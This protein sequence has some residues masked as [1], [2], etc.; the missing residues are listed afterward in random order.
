MKTKLSLTILI[1]IA[2][3]TYFGSNLSYAV[4]IDNGMVYKNDEINF[5][6]HD[7]FKK[8]LFKGIFM[9]SIDLVDPA[10]FDDLEKIEYDEWIT[11]S[12]YEEQETDDIPKL[13][14][15]GIE[16]PDFKI[17]VETDLA[18]EALDGR[19]DIPVVMN[20]TVQYFIDYFT[21]KIRKKFSVWLSR[22]SKYVPMMK[23]I[24]NIFELPEDLVYLALIE[25][26][27]YHHARS[28]ANAVGPWQFIYSTAKRYGLKIDRWVDERRDPEKSTYAAALYLKDLY[29]MFD[30]WY[31]AM[32]GY[33][34]GEYTIMKSIDKFG[35][36]DFWELTK[37]KSMRKET[38]EYIP[39][40]LA[41]LIIAKNPERYG[42]VD[43]NY[44]EPWRYESVYVPGG[45]NLKAV[46]LACGVSYEEIRQLNPALIRGYTP[47]YA[48][49]YEI[50][51]P[52]GKLDEFQK[53][54]PILLSR[55]GYLIKEESRSIVHTVKKGE[56]LAGIS[57][58][59]G[60]SIKRIKELNNIKDPF[61]LKP[62]QKL[63]IYAE[64][65]KRGKK[66]YSNKVVHS[67]HLIKERA[68]IYHKVKSGETLYSISKKYNV[69]I[70][71]IKAWNGKKG[72][73]IVKGEVLKIHKSI[74]P[75]I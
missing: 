18:P 31:L 61:R 34:A 10:S 41:A 36:S 74:K 59:Y 71:D 1:M 33:N 28:R 3:F 19:F 39:K 32:A 69:S 50:R 60:V 56:T 68:I 13:D 57:K 24:F 52:Y 47:P 7:V 9:D 38:K 45:V 49:N 66:A 53:N 67:D 25:S 17:N 27:F 29:S 30:S 40:L 4:F 64:G 51:I 15:S 8:D 26:G 62:G 43:I 12:E 2:V 42:F 21:T 58:R 11:N 46:A 6:V 65:V 16:G 22:S 44:E 54:F 48:E 23:K 72:N 14:L 63:I 20:E 75:S 55:N 35:T 73:K 37:Y 5:S 70:N